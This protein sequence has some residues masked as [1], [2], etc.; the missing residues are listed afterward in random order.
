MSICEQ[1][2]LYVSTRIS[3][4]LAGDSN[5]FSSFFLRKWQKLHHSV[6]RDHV[7]SIFRIWSWKWDSVDYVAFLMPIN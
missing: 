2:M 4:L 3:K 6:N 5:F 7:S 1:A